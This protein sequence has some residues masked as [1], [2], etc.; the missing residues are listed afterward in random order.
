MSKASNQ[1]I[2]RN[3]QNTFFSEKQKAREKI[4]E[5]KEKEREVESIER[6]EIRS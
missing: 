1:K 2:T 5:V 4:E 3:T 6:E